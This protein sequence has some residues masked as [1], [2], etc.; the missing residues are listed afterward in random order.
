MKKPKG[1]YWWHTKNPVNVY[2]RAIG[3]DGSIL[4]EDRNPH[5]AVGRVFNAEVDHYERIECYEVT[6]GWKK[7]KPSKKILNHPDTLKWAE[8]LNEEDNKNEKI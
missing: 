3:K 1:L 7:W 8:I 2:Y 5:E 4:I 6:P